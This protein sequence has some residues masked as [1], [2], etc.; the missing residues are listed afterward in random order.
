MFAAIQNVTSYSVNL[1]KQF[2]SGLA[3]QPNLSMSRTDVDLS[4]PVN[5]RGTV[6]SDLI[7]PLARG[8]GSAAVLA[9]ERAARQSLA[10]TELN[11]RFTAAKGQR[12]APCF[13]RWQR[14]RSWGL[15]SSEAYAWAS[16]RGSW[17][18]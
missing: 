3:I 12:Y 4:P 14:S 15:A 11:Y 9:N 10:S 8:R 1:Q 7:Q 2:A 16:L 13:Y 18:A 6:G 5:G 17:S